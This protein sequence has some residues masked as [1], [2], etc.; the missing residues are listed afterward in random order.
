MPN[1]APGFR[2]V[3]RSHI[4]TRA[5]GRRV[6]VMAGGEL[7]ADSRDAI[8]LREGSYPVVYYFPRA[9]V[10]MERLV[11]TTLSTHCPFKGDASY[12][13]IVGGSKNAAWSY[14]SPYDDMREIRQLLSF[15]PGKVD[16]IEG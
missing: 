13:S 14:E 12:F 8:E 3:P 4:V 15:Y 2:N 11:R 5:A 7:L 6:R 1:P 16:S 10:R 9:D